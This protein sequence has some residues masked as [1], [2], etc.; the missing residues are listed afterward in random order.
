MVEN[1][2]GRK[3]NVMFWFFGVCYFDG[4]GKRKDLFVQVETEGC[5][6]VVECHASPLN[7][8]YKQINYIHRILKKPS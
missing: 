2:K 8:V 1:Q 3:A 7:K 6:M 4:N 5:S